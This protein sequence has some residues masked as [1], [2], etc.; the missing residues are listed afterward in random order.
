MS[1]I[2][3][4]KSLMSKSLVYIIVALFSIFCLLPFLL[5]ISGSITEE[6]SIQKF[7]FALIPKKV[8]F[9]SY[10]YLFLDFTKIFNGYKVS[11]LVTV[12]GTAV[13]LMV[14]ALMAYPLS[15]RDLK[16]RN[17][18]SFFAFFTLLFNGGMVPWYIT[19]TRLGLKD[20][21]I[22]L[23]LPYTISAWNM[24]LLRNYFKSI[25][26]AIHESAKIDGAGEL[27]TFFSIIFPLSLPGIATVGL[28]I[29]LNYWNDWWLGLMLIDKD[30]LFPLQMLLR[31]IVS[32]A[33]FFQTPP[34]GSHIDASRLMPTEGVKMATCILTI[35]P[36]IFVYPY[37][38]KYFV[39]G[40]MIGSVKG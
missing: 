23:I 27:K 16:Y 11:M 19:C 38:Q 3:N 25:P 14:T 1:T 13:S 9:Y 35:G 24:F 17:F 33:Q 8:S 39:K 4:T 22:A 40:I 31:R 2:T 29:S 6:S 34:P 10:R 5:I 37:V 28:F 18:F 15:R 20:T 32:S 12:V 21:L 30:T 36:I 7:G 26:D